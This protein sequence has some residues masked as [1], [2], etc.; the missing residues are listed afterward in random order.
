M[1]RILAYTSPARGHLFPLTPILL[2]LAARGHEVVL[3]TLNAEVPRTRELG[4]DAAAIDPR[5]EQ[6]DLDDHTAKGSRGAVLKAATVFG[7]RAEHESPDLQRAIADE[8]PDALIVD[9][10]CWGAMAA[11]E[12]WGGPWASFCPYPTMLRSVEAPPFGP[13]FPPASGALGRLRDR[14]SAPLIT[15]TVEKAFLPEVNSVRRR[16]NLRSFESADDLVLAPP[17]MLYM[18]A[19]PFEYPRSRWPDSFVMVGPCAWEPESAAPSWLEGVERP[20]VL[21][22]TSSEYQNDGNLIDA[23][24]EALADA[25]FEVVATAPTVDVAGISLPRNA[26]VE[27]FVP[28]GPLLGRAVCA[29][30]HGGM[31]ATQKALSHGVP[32]CAVPFGRDQRE[33]ARRVEVSGAGARL[34]SK[35]LTP[36]RLRAKVFEAIERKPGAERIAEAFQATGGPRTAADAIESRLAA[37]P[38]RAA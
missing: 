14:L 7:R 10:N 1:S 3:R 29:V 28:H 22:T 34:D 4:F 27:Q 9:F 6:I 8:L 37:R 16:L 35:R 32:V 21:V 31:G 12:A 2:E 33:V 30:T 20:I 38:P 19:E 17:L 13:G 26:R 25:P 5:I 18:T 15:G 24:F 36:A 11:A 23:A